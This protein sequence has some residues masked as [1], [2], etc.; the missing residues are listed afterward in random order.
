MMK[1][2]IQALEENNYRKVAS[3]G[4]QYYDKTYTYGL[5]KRIPKSIITLDE[6]LTDPK[7]IASFLITK[8]QH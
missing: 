5:S 1:D 8:V 4:L 2:A 6:K 3:I 7:E